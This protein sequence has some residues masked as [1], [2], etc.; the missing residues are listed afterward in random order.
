MYEHTDIELAYAGHGRYSI[1]IKGELFETY[2]TFIEAVAEY[3]RM[4]KSYDDQRVPESCAS[5]S[6]S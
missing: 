6:E 4:C 2:E 3:E 5:D 1:C